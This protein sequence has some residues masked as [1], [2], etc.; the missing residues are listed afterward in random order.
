MACGKTGQPDPAAPAAPTV[1][2]PQQAPP[3]LPLAATGTDEE[4]P[5]V[6]GPAVA[7]RVA[8]EVG[9]PLAYFRG[10]SAERGH[11]NALLYSRKATARTATAIEDGGVALRGGDKPNG[12][13]KGGAK[14]T[15][16]PRMVSVGAKWC[17]PCSE[18]LG[19]VFDL[20]AQ[21]GVGGHDGE[22][23]LLFV[24]ESTSDEWP[25][26]EVR[27]ELVQKHAKAKKLAKPL[28]IPLWVE[29]RADIDSSWGD[30]VAKLGLLGGDKVALPINLLLDGCGHVQAASSGA[31]DAAKKKAFQDQ[32]AK[33]AAATCAEAPMPLNVAPQRPAAP[34]HSREPAGH[35]GGKEGSKSADPSPA[36]ADPGGLKIPG[37]A[38]DKGAKPADKPTG[39]RAPPT[40]A[41]PAK[42]DK[43]KDDKPDKVE[44][45]KD[46]KPK[47]DKAPA[48][49]AKHP[50]TPASAKGEPKKDETKKDEPKKAEPKKDE[51][52]K[53]EDGAKKADAAPKSEGQK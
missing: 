45:P 53:K 5:A 3:P 34:P 4:E 13:R 19:D 9:Q 35:E 25:L 21:M 1:A 39:E 51:P 18:E 44:K 40:T 52:G 41:E 43:G 10:F 50:E 14:V 22:A 2:D 49:E 6:R 48:A 7:V 29:F 8:S 31:L 33:L 47:D 46:D 32:A 38:A 26:A 28:A 11:E 12:A 37:D 20:A 27:D 36:A 15:G 16:F 42:S 30:A 17:K 23:G 24:V